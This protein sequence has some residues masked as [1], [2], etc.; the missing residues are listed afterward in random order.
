MEI[1]KVTKADLPLLAKAN[2]KIFG[3][4]PALSLAAF[5][6]SLSMGVPG[7][8]LMAEENGKFAGAIFAEKKI[9]FLPKTASISSL[10]ISEGFRGRGLGTML[11]KRSLSALRSRGYKSVS[12]T[13]DGEKC[14]AYHLYSKMGFKKFKLLMLRRL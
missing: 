10:F 9:T 7:A 2:A 1:R 13:V 8:S 12:L 5:K 14:P 3:S 11:L 6:H 4:L